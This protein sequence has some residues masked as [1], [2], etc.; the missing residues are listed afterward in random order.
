M[1]ITKEMLERFN[2]NMYDHV[3]PLQSE[4]NMEEDLLDNFPQ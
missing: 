1:T 4:E 3:P 2:Q